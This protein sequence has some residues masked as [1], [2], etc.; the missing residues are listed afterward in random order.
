MQFEMKCKKCKT[1]RIFVDRVFS[2]K[3]HVELYCLQCGER[4]MV[5]K[6]K[7]AFARLIYSLETA[8]TNAS[9]VK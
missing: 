8:Y 1:G 7:N 5:N 4:K 2:E 9:S 6:K 3:D